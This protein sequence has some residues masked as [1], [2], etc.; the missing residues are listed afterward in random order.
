VGSKDDARALIKILKSV[1]TEA[2]EGG[3][4]QRVENQ[5][6]KEAVI[7]S[8]AKICRVTAPAKAEKTTTEAFILQCEGALEKRKD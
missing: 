2:V 4:E 7:K 6:I 3:S 1:N 8:L 5:E